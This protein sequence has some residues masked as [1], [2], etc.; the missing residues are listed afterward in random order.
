ML[1]TKDFEVAVLFLS[2]IGRMLSR[3]QIQECVWGPAGPSGSRTLDTHVCR[4]RSKL[5]L[6]PEHGWQL[7]AAYRFGYR[8]THVCAG[9]AAETRAPPRVTARRTSQNGGAEASPVL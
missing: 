5:K 9:T 1:T 7:A 6:T 8:L 2:N 3:R 4:I